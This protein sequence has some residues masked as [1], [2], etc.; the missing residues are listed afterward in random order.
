M[1]WRCGLW[2]SF[3]PAGWVGFGMPLVR[4]GGQLALQ[5]PRAGFILAALGWL[6]IPAWSAFV[7]SSQLAETAWIRRCFDDS[8]PARPRR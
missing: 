1:M 3:H 7:L 8:G 2:L 6:T 4:L 5:H